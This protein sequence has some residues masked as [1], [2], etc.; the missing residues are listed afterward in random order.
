MTET[1]RSNR[2]HGKRVMPKVKKTVLTL[3][4]VTA[5]PQKPPCSGDWRCY[6]GVSSGKA[7]LANSL[8]PAV[9]CQCYDFTVVVSG[10]LERTEDVRLNMP[11]MDLSSLR[12]T[13]KKQKPGFCCTCQTCRRTRLS[14]TP[15]TLMFCL[16]IASS[17]RRGS[18]R[19]GQYQIRCRTNDVVNT[20]SGS[21]LK[22]LLV[23][24]TLTGSDT[25][26]FFY[27]KGKKGA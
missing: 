1:I 19:C 23:F 15:I 5:P 20:H 25:I 9:L 27:R 16:T 17:F 4:E 22:E 14:F 10:V 8:G 11:E 12:A 18:F 2:L 13:T 6:I 26:L 7:S 21:V 24:H 3:E